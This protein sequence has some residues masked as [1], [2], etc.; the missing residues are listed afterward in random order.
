MVED[1]FYAIA[2]SFTQHLHYAEYVRRKNEVKPQSATTI[3]KIQR[4]T[5]GRTMIPKELQQKKEAEALAARQKAG[6]EQLAGH[7]GENEDDDDDDAWAGTHL[8]GLLTS[9]RK[10]RSLAGAHAMKSFTR[11]AAGFG[12]ATGLNGPTSQTAAGSPLAPLSSTLRAHKAEIDEETEPSEDDDLD[13]QAYVVTMPATRRAESKAPS[14]S[15]ATAIPD[16]EK[17]GNRV[18]A[19]TAA[20]EKKHASSV[21]TSHKPTRVLK[22]RVQTLFDDLDELPEPA[23]SDTLISANMRRSS[24]ANSTPESVLDDNMIPKTSRHKD[25]PTFLV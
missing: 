24:T 4:P 20:L 17:R 25:V 19:A 3:G 15:S 2:Q 12:Q 23:R 6:L 9:P 13:G 22:S 18:K 5:D 8:H 21:R 16:P 10:V 7:D 14:T 1:E 11:A